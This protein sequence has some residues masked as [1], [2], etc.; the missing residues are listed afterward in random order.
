MTVVKEVKILWKK[1]NLPLQQG[2][3]V[4]ERKVENVLK[5][6]EKER[7]KPGTQD[8]TILFNVTDEKGEWLCQEDKDFYNL[9]HLSFLP[10]KLIA[11]FGFVGIG[12]YL[13]IEHFTKAA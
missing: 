12:A 7:R 13:V 10:L 2:K 1:L 4:V 6:C 11:G 3:S 5:K 8:F 9:H